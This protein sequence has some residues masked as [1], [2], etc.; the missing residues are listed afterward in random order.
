MSEKGRIQN[1][2]C[3]PG[4]RGYDD[5]DERQDNDLATEHDGGETSLR[6]P[7]RQHSSPTMAERRWQQALAVAV[8]VM[9][10]GDENGERMSFWRK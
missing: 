6:P 10:E 1:R 5:G 7:R 9:R 2:E 8:K 4:D 3:L